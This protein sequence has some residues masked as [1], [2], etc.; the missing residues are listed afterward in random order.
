MKLYV[1]SL[2]A[3]GFKI[4]YVRLFPGLKVNPDWWFAEEGKKSFAFWI[5]Y[6]RST[7]VF[8]ARL[9]DAVARPWI[10]NVGPTVST[11]MH[12]RCYAGSER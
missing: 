4:K 5:V 2:G 8:I 7:V 3:R 9:S 1:R 10:L 11:L 6:D 12:R